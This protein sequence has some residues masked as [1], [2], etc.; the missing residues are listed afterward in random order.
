[1]LNCMFLVL[2]VQLR[3]KA[4]FQFAWSCW[5]STKDLQLLHGDSTLVDVF[6]SADVRVA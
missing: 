6:L 1:M 5:V 3:V 2:R 4:Q